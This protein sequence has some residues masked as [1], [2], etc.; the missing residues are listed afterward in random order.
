[1]NKEAFSAIMERA[2]ENVFVVPTQQE[3]FEIKRAMRNVAV[4]AIKDTE[5]LDKQAL[6]FLQNNYLS[7][8]EEGAEKEAVEKAF[9]AVLADFIKDEER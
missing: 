3:V 5:Y 4:V 9:A 7:T 2:T 6:E 8:L 1:M